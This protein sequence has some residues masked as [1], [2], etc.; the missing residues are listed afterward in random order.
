MNRERVQELRDVMAGIPESLVDLNSVWKNDK[1]G[2][3]QPP[4]PCGAVAC[5][6]GWALIYPPFV[7]SGI[8]LGPDTSIGKVRTFL[9]LHMSQYH[10]LYSRQGHETGTDKQIALRRLDALLASS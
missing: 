6:A 5:I 9:G 8:R 10:V 4:K 7:E 1:C 2:Y 3:R